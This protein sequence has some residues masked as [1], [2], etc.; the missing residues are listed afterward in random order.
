MP[1]IFIIQIALS[2]AAVGLLSK[3]IIKIGAMVDHCATTPQ[4]AKTV[5]V[6]VATGFIAIGSGGALLISVG[7]S[8]LLDVSITGLMISLGLTSLCLGL[9]FVHA[10][11]TLR[12]VLQNPK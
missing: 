2:L 10:I 4:Q 8:T 11:A 1:I 7:V 9:G 6:T 3:M 5:S 12:A